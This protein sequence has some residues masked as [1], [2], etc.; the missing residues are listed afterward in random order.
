MTPAAQKKGPAEAATSPSHGS[1]NP[2]KDMDMNVH[3]NITAAAGSARDAAVAAAMRDLE[4]DICSLLSMA[5]ILGDLLD[6]DLVGFQ[7]GRRIS[8]P[9]RGQTMTVYLGHDQVDYLSFAWNDVINRA[10]RLKEKF[11]AAH[12]GEVL[13]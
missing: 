10:V 12:D 9:A 2:A 6:S 5:R 8:S 4:G 13:P 11:Y 7:N 1:T 3:S